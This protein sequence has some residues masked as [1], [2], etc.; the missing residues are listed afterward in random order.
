MDMFVSKNF[1][2]DLIRHEKKPSSID[3]LPVVAIDRLQNA[4]ILLN[5][6][7]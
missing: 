7:K 6:L 5:T 4:I 1:V 2:S 3:R